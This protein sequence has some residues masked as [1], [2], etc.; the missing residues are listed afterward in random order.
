MA[1][2]Q[3]LAKQPVEL[4][5]DDKN[6][7]EVR[8]RDNLLD[9]AVRQTDEPRT[10]AGAVIG[11]LEGLSDGGDAL[12]CFG[13]NSAGETVRARSMVSLDESQLG[14]EAVL[15][16]EQGDPR[17]PIVLGLLAAP[18]ARRPAGA[19][20]EPQ[21]AATPSELELDGE[22]L[23]LTANREIVL[24]CGKA[25][26]TLTKAGKILIRGAYLL[27]RSSGVNRIKGGSVQI[28]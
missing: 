10:I 22:R 20:A 24:R 6:R 11:K 21:D 23:V 12:V 1:T 16:F 28:N 18:V 2:K 26:I 3:R 25:T 14:R 17:K 7:D 9:L 4:L 19:E 15:I 8:Q 13:R 27:S 5:H